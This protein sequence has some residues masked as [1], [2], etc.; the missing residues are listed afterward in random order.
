M[1]LA[2]QVILV[3][4]VGDELLTARAAVQR[5]RLLRLLVGGALLLDTLLEVL[6]GDR[7]QVGNATLQIVSM[8]VGFV[9]VALD[10][11]RLEFYVAIQARV[12]G[13]FV[14]VCLRFLIFPKSFDFLS[15]FSPFNWEFHNDPQ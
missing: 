3:R 12:T 11:G 15:I 13:H 14:V 5:H 7:R 6:G 10:V 4:F 1:L 8:P 2:V 9:V